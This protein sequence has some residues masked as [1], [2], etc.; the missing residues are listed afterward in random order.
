MMNDCQL[1]VLYHG[2]MS[3]HPHVT[4]QSLQSKESTALVKASCVIIGSSAPH[5]HATARCQRHRS[6]SL[7]SADRGVR[8]VRRRESGVVTKEGARALKANAH[9]DG[10]AFARS[11]GRAIRAQRTTGASSTQSLRV[12]KG[13][14]ARAEI[15][16]GASTTSGFR[17]KWKSPTQGVHRGDCAR[18]H[19]RGYGLKRATRTRF[20]HRHHTRRAM[21]GTAPHSSDR[22]CGPPA[23]SGHG[24]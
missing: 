23:R 22:G 10:Y 3:C 15:A 7:T 6:E 4:G 16:C 1:S 5:P 12:S 8:I 20:A 18:H 9:T 14:P 24:K 13:F 2:A 11:S 19:S 21:P 17:I